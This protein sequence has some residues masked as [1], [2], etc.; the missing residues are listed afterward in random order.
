MA[1]LRD[2]I[3]GEHFLVYYEGEDTGW[4]ERVALWP[5]AVGTWVVLPRTATA[6]PTTSI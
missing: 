3:P 2:L 1:F 5:V 6:T 4:N